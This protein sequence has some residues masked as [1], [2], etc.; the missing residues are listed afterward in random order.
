[1][2][3]PYERARPWADTLEKKTTVSEDGTRIYYETLGKGERV[4]LLANGLG[5]RLYAWEPLVER[6]WQDYRLITWDYRGLF[7]SDTPRVPRR[8]CLANHVEDAAAILK[9]ET[10]RR[11]VLFGWSMGVQVSLDVAATYSELVGGLVLLNGTYGHALGSG[12]QPFFSVPYLP[13]R[14]HATIEWMR[15]HPQIEERIRVLSRLTELPTTLLFTLTAGSRALSLRPVLRRYMD[16]VL[17]ESFDN[18]MRLFQELDA[19][20]VY[21]VLPEIEA[22]ALVISGALDLMAPARQSR[23]IAR[24]MPAARRLAL[25]RASHFCLLERPEVVLP[26]IEDFLRED[27]RW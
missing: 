7:E 20:S 3:D 17:G 26:A 23:E 10:V 16:D 15:R 21:H 19:H 13:K 6:Y 8:L 12:F 14:L 18:F 11:A 1:V 5:G 4:L 24:R 2:R 25:F 9:A 22:P 27:A